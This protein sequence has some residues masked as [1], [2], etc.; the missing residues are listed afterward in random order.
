MACPVWSWLLASATAL[1]GPVPA[2]HSRRFLKQRLIY[3]PRRRHD[4]THHWSLSV[5]VEAAAHGGTRRGVCVV[6]QEEEG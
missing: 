5:R 4:V 6:T 3:R 2:M 1:H